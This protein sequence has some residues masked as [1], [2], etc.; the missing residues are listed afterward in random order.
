MRNVDLVCDFSV[1]FQDDIHY[2]LTCTSSVCLLTASLAVTVNQWSMTIAACYSYAPAIKYASCP[3]CNARIPDVRVDIS[4][5]CCGILA[6]WAAC[7]RQ[8]ACH[9]HTGAVHT[10]LQEYHLWPC[11][12]LPALHETRLQPPGHM[13]GP[14]HITR[15]QCTRI[16]Y[17]AP[18]R[19]SPTFCSAL[20]L[21]DL[22]WRAFQE[23]EDPSMV[24]KPA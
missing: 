22:A 20:Y 13:H 6:C 5:A 19:Q 24:P 3:S 16:H 14:A 1:L 21:P 17:P 4:T 15:P 9:P 7:L 8:R 23:A 10:Q 18:S 11:E 2:Q 12:E